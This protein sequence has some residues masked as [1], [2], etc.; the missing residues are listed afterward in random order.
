MI[1]GR[2]HIVALLD[3]GPG[4]PLELRHAAKSG[5]E[6]LDRVQFEGVVLGVEFLVCTNTAGERDRARY[7]KPGEDEKQPGN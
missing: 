5:V 4:E 1:V 2:I 3:L 7:E 6:A